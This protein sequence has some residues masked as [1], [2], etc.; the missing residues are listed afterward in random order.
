MPSLFICI[1]PGGSQTKIIYQLPRDEKPRYLL[2]AP[3]VEEI[4]GDNLNRYLA[5]ESKMSNPSPIRQSYLEVNQKTFVVGYFASKFDPEDRLP[6]IKYENALYKAL[7][8]VGVIAELNCLNSQ[9]ISLQLAVLLPWNEYEDR[10]KFSQK[11]EEYL[12]DFVFRG[13]SYSVKLDKFICRPEGGGLAAIHTKKQGKEWQQNKQLGILMFGHRNIT[14]LNFEYGDLT[15]DSPLI[16]FSKF[17]DNVIERT[18]GLDRDRIASAI[19]QGLDSKKAEGYEYPHSGSQTFHPEWFKLD[20]I[21]TLANAKDP[22]L[23]QQEIKDVCEAIDIAT[24][25]YW[26]TVSKWL[27]R[28]F[29]NNLSEVVISG[30]ASRFLSPNLERY[31]NCGHICEKKEDS[32]YR[33]YFRTGKYQ[34]LEP[35]QHFTPI[36]WGA[37]LTKEIAEI[38]ALDGEKEAENSLSYRLI[39][40]YG[41]FDLLVSKNYPKG[42]SSSSKKTK[43][44]DKAS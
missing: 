28:M 15:G 41:L 38:L 25:E 21:Q 23:R 12:D 14:A 20:A 1:D 36:I 22:D 2:M 29:P 7:A 19:F 43:Q 11:L 24:E 44:Q 26:L 4:S 40:A 33:P 42:S 13:Q 32:Y 35:E 3:F 6:E 10:A 37:G 9:K 8:A 17:L 18:S 34:P 31:F 39:D 30:G 16:G 5:K 27:N